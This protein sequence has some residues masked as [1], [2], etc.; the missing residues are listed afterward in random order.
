MRDK[1]SQRTVENCTLHC[2]AS[3]SPDFYEKFARTIKIAYLANTVCPLKI[4]AVATEQSPSGTSEPAKLA[5]SLSGRWPP[6]QNQLKQIC[7]N[8]SRTKRQIW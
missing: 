3:L 1:R 4:R 8:P 6:L 5:Q 2:L 7:P